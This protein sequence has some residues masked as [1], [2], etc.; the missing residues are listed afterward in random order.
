MKITV[1]KMA[2][3]TAHLLTDLPAEAVSSA[4]S[5]DSVA[6]LPAATPFFVK[7]PFI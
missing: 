3:P 6:V 7:I 5:A 4:A 2:A 1:T